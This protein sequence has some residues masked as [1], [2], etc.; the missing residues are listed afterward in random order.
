MRNTYLKTVF[1]T[2][3][4]HSI[5]HDVAFTTNAVTLS[6]TSHNRAKVRKIKTRLSWR[7][8]TCSLEVMAGE[9]KQGKAKWTSLFNWTFRS[10]VK[11]KFRIKTF[12][13][14]RIT[15][16]QCINY[17]TLKSN[18]TIP[19]KNASYFNGCTRRNSWHLELKQNTK[20]PTGIFQLGGGKQKITM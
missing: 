8:C 3:T 20:A 15:K 17:E 7:P 5:V 19:L 14:Y 12:S 18:E 6:I 10:T 16:L 11:E 4:I 9:F 13:M 1:S 2:H